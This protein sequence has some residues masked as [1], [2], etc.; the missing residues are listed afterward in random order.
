LYEGVTKSAQRDESRWLV[1][2]RPCTNLRWTWVHVCPHFS[3]RWYMTTKTKWCRRDRVS[4]SESLPSLP[5]LMYMLYGRIIKKES[6]LNTVPDGSLRNSDANTRTIG[7]SAYRSMEMYRYNQAKNCV[8][9][10]CP[11]RSY[12]DMMEDHSLVIKSRLPLS[13]LRVCKI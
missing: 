6:I 12:Q 4:T 10:D 9:L 8:T 1:D 11:V 13:R 7:H 5:L 3:H 2:T